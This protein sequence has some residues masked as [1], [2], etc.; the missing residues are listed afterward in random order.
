VFWAAHERIAALVEAK[1]TLS[2]ARD[3][4][5]NGFAD[6]AGRKIRGGE[7]QRSAAAQIQAVVATVDSK[8]S[9]EAAGSA[10]QVERTSGFAMALHER[11]ALEGLDRADENRS[12]GSLRLA[13]DVEHVMRAVIEEYVCMAGGEIHRANSRSGTAKVVSRGIAGRVGLDFHDA[14]ADAAG[15]KI[16]HHDFANEKACELNRSDRKFRP[17]Q[18]AK[19]KFFVR[20]VHGQGKLTARGVIRIAI[21]W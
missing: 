6:S 19:R 16:V 13:D 18:A 4:D 3:A 10:R 8:S 20:M 21:N 2:G 9:G 1:S 7:P 11:E 5:P 14:P 17:L 15:R 12:R